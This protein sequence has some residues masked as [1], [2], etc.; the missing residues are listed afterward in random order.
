MTVAAKRMMTRFALNF[1]AIITELIRDI[2]YDFFRDG[3]EVEVTA[4]WLEA[5]NKY[6]RAAKGSTVHRCDQC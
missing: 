5:P 4:G 3:V 2:V 6:A 1:V